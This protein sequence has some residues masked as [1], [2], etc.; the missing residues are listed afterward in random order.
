MAQI[1]LK[2]TKPVLKEVADGHLNQHQIAIH[3]ASPSLLALLD[4]A[5]KNNRV[6]VD[7]N[8]AFALSIGDTS[9]TPISI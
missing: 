6:V 1:T 7:V 3:G 5:S 2:V 8:G 9:Q 4:T